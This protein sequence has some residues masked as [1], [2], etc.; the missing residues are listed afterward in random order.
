MNNEDVNS[1]LEREDIDV[2]IYGVALPSDKR[3]EKS[4]LDRRGQV[5]SS[6]NDPYNQDRINKI[7]RKS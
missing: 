1:A 2:N 6:E 3:F 5:V 7:H 4:V